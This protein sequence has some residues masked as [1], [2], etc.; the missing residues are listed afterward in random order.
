VAQQEL[1][2]ESKPKYV[3]ESEPGNNNTPNSTK[4]N[5]F[6]SLDQQF[7]QPSNYQTTTDPTIL[8][9]TIPSQGYNDINQAKVTMT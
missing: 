1:D 6:S 8:P 7:T 9:Q 3:S 5:F 2:A 4:T